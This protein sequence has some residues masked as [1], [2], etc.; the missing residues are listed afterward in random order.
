[1]TNKM[2]DIKINKLVIN[3]GTGDD[4]KKL[5]NARKLIETVTGRK[6]MNEIAKR[7]IPTFGITKGQK[8]GTFVT[9]RGKRAAE[10]ARKLL[11]AVE[12]KVKEESITSN[13]LSF[14][15]KEY[16]DISGV[17]YDPNIGMLGMNVNL[18]FKRDGLRVAF[19]KR[20]VSR[21]PESHRRISKGEIA[22]YLKNQFNAIVE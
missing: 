7:R 4:E 11:D 6:P 15:I 5:A 2:R 10:L 12:N 17:K 1:M 18:S 8:I 20:R 16:I 19:R 22:E 13:S 14:G 9:L 3:M 21:I